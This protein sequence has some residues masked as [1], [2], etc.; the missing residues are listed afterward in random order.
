[1]GLD[2]AQRCDANTDMKKNRRNRQHPVPTARID[3]TNEKASAEA[4]PTALAGDTVSNTLDTPSVE[5]IVPGTAV[6]VVGPNRA[7]P[8]GAVDMLW[9]PM[10]E[11][12]V[13]LA[14]RK[15]D[16]PCQD[17]AKA[18]SIPRPIVVLADGSGSSAVSEIGAQTVVRGVVRLLDTLHLHLLTDLLDSAVPPEN[19]PL[20]KAALLIVKHA[21]GLLVDVAAQHRRSV[22]DFTCTLLVMVAGARRLLWIKVGDGALVLEKIRVGVPED[23]S[24]STILYECSTVG[25]SG[26]GEFAN[27]TQF[28]DSVN[29]E[30][31]QFG[32]VES[33]NITGIVAMSDGAAEKLVSN[34][35]SAVSTRLTKLLGKLREGSLKRSDLTKM[36][37]EEKFYS[38]TASDDCSIALVSRVAL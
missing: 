3:L 27:E 25:K 16:F 1:M 36:F 11:A 32:I 17:A 21:G 28:L 30:Q 8:T 5:A 10:E 2:I 9:H 18:V 7:T 35:G 14:H 34:D 23:P 12:V 24:L 15:N 19:E 29:P 31:V 37:Y 13:G 20:R 38:N 33:E 26:K 6:S 4:I 22:R